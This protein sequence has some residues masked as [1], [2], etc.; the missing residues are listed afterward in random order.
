MIMALTDK[1]TV[2]AKAVEQKISTNRVTLG[3]DEVRYGVHNNIPVGIFVSVTTARKRRVRVGVQGPGG[4][5]E[6]LMDILVSVY[7][8][9]TGIEQDERLF[10]DQLAESI[11]DLL[12]DDITLGG[13]TIDGYVTDME[14]G[15][16][17]RSGSMFRTVQLVFVGRTRTLIQ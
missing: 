13:I 5:T 9:R 6:N 16:E 3:I 15:V 10:V 4:R 17:F 12:H 14:H 2:V 8:S 11:E 7:N 1:G